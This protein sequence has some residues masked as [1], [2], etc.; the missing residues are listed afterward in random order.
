MKR[1][2]VF[3]MFMLMLQPL[4]SQ[5]GKTT[6]EFKK[7]EIDLTYKN[8]YINNRT[9]WIGVG[10]FVGILT[11]NHLSVEKQY[12]D[13]H[14][15]QLVAITVTCATVYSVFNKPDRRDKKYRRR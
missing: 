10:V 2:L 5:I 1:L 7:L 11:I 8:N 15:Y 12:R 9:V 4:F 6:E 13:S 14:Y 3:T